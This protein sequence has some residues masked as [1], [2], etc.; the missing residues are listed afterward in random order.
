MR[1]YVI[2]RVLS[3]FIIRLIRSDCILP[4]NV[5]PCRVSSEVNQQSELRVSAGGFFKKSATR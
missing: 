5:D 1:W 2:R 3:N 4:L